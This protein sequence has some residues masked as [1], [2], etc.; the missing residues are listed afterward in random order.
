MEKLI[1]DLSW[2]TYS[3]KAMS[4]SEGQRIFQQQFKNNNNGNNGL[5]TYM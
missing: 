5:F 3:S 2:K 1:W 4:F